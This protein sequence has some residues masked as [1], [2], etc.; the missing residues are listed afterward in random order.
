[1]SGSGDATSEIEFKNQLELMQ[2][3]N[4]A[5]LAFLLELRRIN[6][7]SPDDFKNVSAGLNNLRK[8]SASEFDP[9]TGDVFVNRLVWLHKK[10]HVEA[11]VLVMG[12]ARRESVTTALHLVLRRKVLKTI[13]YYSDLVEKLISLAETHARTLCVEYTYW[14]PA[15]AGTF[16]HF[17]LHFIYPMLRDLERFE[18]QFQ[19]WNLYPGGIGATNGSTLPIDRESL[20]RSL[21]FQGVVRHC[22]D[23][24]WRGDVVAEMYTTLGV[25]AMNLSRLAQDF[26]ILASKEFSVLKWP[27]SGSRKSYVM[28]QKNNPYGLCVVRGI[29]SELMGRLSAVFMAQ[30][31]A[32]G[33]IDNRLFAYGSLPQAMDY[34]WEALFHLSAVDQ[35]VVD[36]AQMLKH[37][38]NSGVQTSYLA[39]LLV[40]RFQLPYARVH[41]ILKA[42]DWT[43]ESTGDVLAEKL[44]TAFDISFE[45]K[46]IKDLVVRTQNFREQI[47]LRNGYGGTSATQVK[48]MTDEIRDRLK[49]VRVRASANLG[50]NEK[51]EAG[52]WSNTGYIGSDGHGRTSV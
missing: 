39:E 5:D 38:E 49:T 41:E 51:I 21:G 25:A 16:G 20:A 40:A 48:A 19:I 3:M 28:P 7:I 6:L 18:K 44:R 11:D 45:P 22:R 46:E 33:Q 14:Q 32:S 17:V 24:M 1:M 35:I 8:V 43:F 30:H 34:F 2:D 13:E 15:Q 10:G 36:E 27:E 9:K 37:L 50:M 31:T 4:L 47:D 52:I 26:Q 29:A 42:M 23:A 12:R